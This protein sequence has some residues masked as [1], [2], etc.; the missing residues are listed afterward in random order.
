MRARMPS[1]PR[2]TDRRGLTV[3]EL[4]LSM[5]LFSAL[6][7]AF[8]QAVQMQGVQGELESEEV[9]LSLRLNETLQELAWSMAY[10]GFTDDGVYPYLFDAGV[11][12]AGFAVHAH[13][14][15]NPPVSTGV[16][17][18]REVV[19]LQAR[20]L[21]ADDRP[22]IDADG[23]MIWGAEERSFVVVSDQ[24]G[25]NRIEEC[26]DGVSQRVVCRNVES[27]VVDDTASGGPAVPLGCLRIQLV[28][29]RTI[30]NRLVTRSGE[31]IVRLRNGGIRP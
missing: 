22:D 19:F 24:G 31:V 26:L 20:D 17:P 25:W 7:L 1:S 3:V 4:V 29:S 6:M 13:A 11:P 21:D 30:G 15:P 14:V 10:S 28:L 27:L 16:W 2:T 18:S 5:A 12:D 9:E 8:S 23:E